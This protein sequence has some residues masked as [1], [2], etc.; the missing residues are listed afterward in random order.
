MKEYH[1]PFEYEAANKFDPDRIVD[2]YIEDFNYSRFIRSSRNVYLVGERGTGKTMT[3]LYNSFPVQFRKSR[4]AGEKPDLQVVGVYIPCN[5]PLMHRRE[6]ELLE[7]IKAAVISEHLLVLNTMFALA[8]ALSLVGDMLS[9]ENQRTLSDEMEY[10]LNM[11]LP[12]SRPFPQAL[13][14]AIEK[15]VRQTQRVINSKAPEAFY[16]DA[17]SFGSDILPLLGYLRTTET[18]SNTHFALMFDDAHDLN[19]FQIRALNSWIAFRGNDYV[20]FKIATAKVDRP[21]LVTSSGG[22][23]L[24]GH[25]F[26]IIDME[27]PYQNRDSDFGK[28]ARRIVQ[29]RLES[30]G[31]T[32]QVEDFFRVNP[33]FEKDLTKCREEAASEAREK[34]PIGNE[35]Q[36]NDYVYKYAR[37]MYFRQRS[38]KANRPPYSGFE[39]LVHLSTGVV[40]NLLE[41]CWWMYDKVY[42]E[43][44]RDDE[45]IV[46]SY[47]PPDDQTEV[48]LERSKRKWE[49]IRDGLDRS[50]EGC[51]REEAV[52]I[53]Q[54]FDNLAILFRERLHKHKS[55]PRAI[56]FT[57]SE[58]EFPQMKELIRLFELAR[59]AQIM[60]TYPSSAKDSGRRETYYVPNRILWPDR[61]LDPVGQHAR[62]SIRA[63]C[64]WR[65]AK[66]NKKIPLDSGDQEQT[67]GYLNAQE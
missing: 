40:R 29:K 18:F 7:T 61:G 1:N 43:M 49:W 66:Y 47:I 53:Y 54:L 25:D 15:E 55:E 23:I 42:S 48:I 34:Y 38:S 39:T 67:T 45:T 10:T 31:I 8:R 13:A 64:L 24:D 3:L 20:S 52:Q 30:A 14:L 56:S 5:T 51:S 27:Q 57:V 26:T 21:T 6:Y 59:K 33:T 63:S 11:R 50:I 60:Y 65:A 12:N 2:Y 58:G 4:L 46:V 41:P 28:F 44:R 35:K 36:I 32:S 19:E 16:T 22:T 17:R 37:A 9:A 62:V